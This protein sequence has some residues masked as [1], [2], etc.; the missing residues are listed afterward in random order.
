MNSASL[1]SSR[2]TASASAGRSLTRSNR[3]SA[4]SL[5]IT[6]AVCSVRLASG[7]R[8]SRGGARTPRAGGAP[9]VGVFGVGLVVSCGQQVEEAR[10]G[11][12]QAFV[13][14]QQAADHL[15]ADVL[16]VIVIVDAEIAAQE[17]DQRLVGGG[18]PEGDGGAFHDE[19]AADTVQPFELQEE[20]GVVAP[21]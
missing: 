3:G 11:I 18:P 9:V 17:V 1:R 15:L 7:S 20:A 13:E 8:R 4:K 21:A 19:T 14:G 12:A 16:G 2:A 5:P 10:H 6:A